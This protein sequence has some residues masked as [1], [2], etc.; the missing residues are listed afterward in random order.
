M[1][2]VDGEM[3]GPSRYDLPTHRNLKTWP[4]RVKYLVDEGLLD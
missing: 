4:N 2:R 3:T 1:D